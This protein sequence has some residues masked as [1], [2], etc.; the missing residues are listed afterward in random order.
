M[1]RSMTCRTAAAIFV[2]GHQ[3][4]SRGIGR[5]SRFAMPAVNVLAARPDPLP[6]RLVDHFVMALG[7]GLA[8]GLIGCWSLLSVL[9]AR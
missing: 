9:L 2:A 1:S 7:L 4:I 5:R 6:G 3:S 8:L